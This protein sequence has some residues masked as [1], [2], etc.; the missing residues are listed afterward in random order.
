MMRA[1]YLARE[2]HVRKWIAACVGVA[3]LL[4]GEAV[5]AQQGARGATTASA[6]ARQTETD[7]YTRYELLAPDS[8]SFRI[9]YEVTA[10]TAGA[11]YYYNPIR[12]GS[13]VTDEA[14]YDAMSGEAL[15]FEIVSGAAAQKDPLMAEADAGG[16]Y[17]KVHLA[18][19]VPKEGQARLIILKTY[20]D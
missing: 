19:P 1:L 5:R 6:A 20:K 10:T 3:L 17:I 8:A 15:Q 18:R 11:T 13:V 12:K 9:R 7:E 2:N 14:V 4:S 16:N